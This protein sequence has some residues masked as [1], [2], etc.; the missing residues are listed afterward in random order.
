MTIQDHGVPIP[1]WHMGIYFFGGF[2]PAVFF[3][4]ASVFSRPLHYLIVPAVFLVLGF[5]CT[6]DRRAYRPGVLSVACSVLVVIGLLPLAIGMWQDIFG[7][8]RS[9]GIRRSDAVAATITFLPWLS[10]MFLLWQQWVVVI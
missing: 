9:G 7:I 10:G 1:Q 8:L 4:L 6:F 3:L 2:L 5:F